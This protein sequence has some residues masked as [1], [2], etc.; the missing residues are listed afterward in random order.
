MGLGSIGIYPFLGYPGIIWRFPW[1][2]MHFTFKLNALYISNHM[3]LNTVSLASWTAGYSNC[4]SFCS[5]HHVL[6]SSTFVNIVGL[7]TK[8]VM[9]V[10]SGWTYW[11]FHAA[12]SVLKTVN[13]KAVLRLFLSLK[14][15]NGNQTLKL[16]V[17]RSCRSVNVVLIAQPPSQYLS[18]P[19][20]LWE[21]LTDCLPSWVI[22]VVQWMT[23]N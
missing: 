5:E 22:L 19:A 2:N 23:Y 3:H 21:W 6:L 14:H 18:M 4:T 15:H 11:H 13:Q 7:M 20:D 9:T 10:R 1:S 17:W 16:M 8:V 12:T